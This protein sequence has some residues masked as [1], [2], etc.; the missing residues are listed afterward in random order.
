MAESC[1]VP[2]GDRRVAHVLLT[3]CEVAGGSL[4]EQ[5]RRPTRSF[6]DHLAEG[7]D[8]VGRDE[9]VLPCQRRGMAGVVDEC[10]GHDSVRHRRP[11]RRATCRLRGRRG[12]SRRC[13]A[14]LRGG[15][16]CPRRTTVLSSTS[17]VASTRFGQCLVRRA[18][19]GIAE[20]VEVRRHEVPAGLPRVT[21]V[22]RRAGVGVR[23]GEEHARGIEPE[24]LET[25]PRTCHSSA[26]SCHQ[27]RSA[28]RRTSGSS[29]SATSASAVSV[30]G[31]CVPVETSSVAGPQTRMKMPG[32]GVMSLRATPIEPAN[33]RCG[34]GQIRRCREWGG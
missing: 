6:L 25:A 19:G 4:E 22:G 31:R 27:P 13:I 23:E 7:A 34:L 12:C 20:R 30:S 3:R 29:P 32:G 11:D 5:A 16:D 18:D 15:R 24:A 33:R 21:V 8:E 17:G 10:R 14:H 26:G 9:R 28:A 2:V 1:A